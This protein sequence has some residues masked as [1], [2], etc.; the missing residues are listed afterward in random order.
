MGQ[1]SSVDL[2]RQVERLPIKTNP[3]T[4]AA[5]RQLFEVADRSGKGYLNKQEV[6]A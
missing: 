5:L 3:A 6:L 2:F 4:D 1:A